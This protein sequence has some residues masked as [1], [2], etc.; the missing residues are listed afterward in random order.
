MS[1]ASGLWLAAQ[2]L[3]L[4]SGSATRRDMLVATGIPVETHEPD[5]DERAIEARL[6]EAGATSSEIAQALAAHKARAV[7]LALPGRIVLGADQT[8]S[9]DGQR[10]HK[11]RDETAA[12]V[13]L[14]ALSGKAHRLHSAFVLVRD[15]E[16]LSEGVSVARMTMRSLSRGFITAYAKAAGP[17]VTTSVGGYQI[18]GLG[19]QLF[20]TIEGD[21]STIL[22]LPL[23]PVLGALRSLD[24]LAR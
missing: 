18:E 22:G 21:H 2:P 13:Q 17:A 11:P 9:C 10:F 14:A 24:C 4:A 5:V 7:S 1:E 12:Q 8:L 23:L 20:E 19:V 3:V 15:G 16:V 6:T